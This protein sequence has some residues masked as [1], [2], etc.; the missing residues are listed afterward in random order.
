MTAGRTR[1][2]TVTKDIFAG[3]VFLLGQSSS[4]G[5]NYQAQEGNSSMNAFLQ[6][7]AP[8]GVGTGYRFDVQRNA[9]E[10]GN[11]SYLGNG[12]FQYNGRY[13][14]YSADIR[15]TDDQ[16][17]YAL[18]VS[19][20]VAF[21]N[22]SGYPTRPISDSFAVV[23]V[24]KIEGVKVYASNQFVA[25]TNKDGE[26][27]VPGMISYY[28][29]NISI[30]DTD[31]PVNYSIS[32][33]AQYVSTPYRGGGLVEFKSVRLQ[34]LGGRF[35]IMD[36]GRKMPA[37]YWG[38]ELQIKN[39]NVASVVGKN[40]EFYFENISPGIYPARLFLNDKEC[41]F[42]LHV[43]ESDSMMVDMGDVVCEIH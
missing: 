5:I 29:N 39:M 26:A 3:V 13:G 10:V 18:N 1:A 11:V 35:I 24:G 17:S 2:A 43:P 4:G 6:K 37:E 42:D 22:G 20:G 19:G 31:I 16:M 21:V 38:V 7:N 30:D 15:D 32:D 23:K 9:P 41:R 8:T 34:G 36:K 25:T 28:N 12:S 27:V 33:L 14:I 40:G